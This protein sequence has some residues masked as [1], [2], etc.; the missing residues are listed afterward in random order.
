VHRLGLTNW[1]PRA[2]ISTSIMATLAVHYSVDVAILN[3]YILNT[4]L[5][6]DQETV[7]GVNVFVWGGVSMCGANLFSLCR[8]VVGANCDPACNAC[9]DG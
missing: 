4:P 5:D 1:L 3:Y 9:V 6:L 2:D 7:L 8:P